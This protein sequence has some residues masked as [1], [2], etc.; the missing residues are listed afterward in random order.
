MQCPRCGLINSSHQTKC[1]CGYQ[2]AAPATT[3]ATAEPISAAAQKVS[4]DERN[5]AVGVHAC[6]LAGMAIPM[7]NLIG[8]IVIYFSKKNESAFVAAHARTSINFQLTFFLIV[9]MAL[10]SIFLAIPAFKYNQL[11][12]VIPAVVFC[13]AM[14]GFGIAS[15]VF[16]IIGL[17]RA[18]EGKVYRYPLAI[19]F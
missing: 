13:T 5:W 18:R 9:V 8:P 19:P 15:L 1:Q 4:D 12:M 16:S 11:L 3:Y 2:L 10:L 14:I 17:I 6:E 7:A